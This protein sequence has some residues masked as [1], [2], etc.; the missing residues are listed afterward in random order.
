[1][2]DLAAPPDLPRLPSI[3]GLRALEAAA[4]LGN[5]DR[6]ADELAVTA[7]ARPSAAA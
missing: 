2:P 1:M 3:E 5:F 4:R 6:A 7:S